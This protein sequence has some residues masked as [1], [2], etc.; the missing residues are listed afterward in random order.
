[1]KKL[2]SVLMLSILVLA[3]CGSSSNTGEVSGSIT[4]GISGTPTELAT[5]KDL[6]EKFTQE[7]GVEVEFKQYTDFNTEIQAELIGG[8]APDV[9]P[10]DAYF[11][12]FLASQGV[13]EPVDESMFDI[14]QY[15]ANLLDEF[16]VDGQLYAMT[17]YY[18]TLAI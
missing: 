7:K 18:S 12:P 5:Y 16:R 3:G 11:F 15:E 10:I 17:K 9:F 8:T 14:D 4:V 1:M 13:L 6:G 2:L